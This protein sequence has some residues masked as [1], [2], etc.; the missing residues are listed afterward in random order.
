MTKIAALQMSSQVNVP[1]NLAAASRLLEQAANE[2]VRLAVLPEM[3]AVM[4]TDQMDKVEQAEHY[5]KGPIQDFLKNQAIKHKLWIVS[6]TI[7]IITAD[8][9]RVRA[10]CLVYNDEGVVALR[11]DKMHLFDIHLSDSDE[12]F[13]ESHST[14][15][16]DTVGLVDTPFGTLGVAVCYD[17]RFPELFRALFQSGAEIIAVPS[18]YIDTTGR[19]HW[20]TLLRARAIENFSYVIGA[21]QHGVHNQ[22]RKS[23]GHSMIVN[24]WGE[25]VSE[26]EEGDAVVS[27][28]IDLAYLHKIRKAIPIKMH[29]RIKVNHQ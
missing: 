5:G 9:I 8:R 17:L 6:G 21:D 22:T 11:Y 16:G 23:Y 29:Q 13:N 28:E 1:Q 27:A 25:V 7:P 14:E 12:K 2:G 20:K 18:A 4:G 10:A 3:F 15:P 26:A 19:A 24:P